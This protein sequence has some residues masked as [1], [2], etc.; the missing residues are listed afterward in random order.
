MSDHQLAGAEQSLSAR[1]QS[2]WASVLEDEAGADTVLLI[3]TERVAVHSLV[4]RAR[5]AHLWHLLR[6]RG[7]ERP[8]DDGELQ[9]L[10]FPHLNPKA[11]KIAVKFLYTAEVGVPG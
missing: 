3:G 6:T 5:C 9:T 7:A 1:L 10:R 2:D 4:L 11:V 8:R